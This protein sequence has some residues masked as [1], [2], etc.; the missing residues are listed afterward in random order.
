MVGCALEDNILLLSLLLLLL[1]NYAIFNDLHVSSFPFWTQ[2]PHAYHAI[3]MTTTIGAQHRAPTYKDAK[4]WPKVYKNT[5]GTLHGFE[6]AKV[7]SPLDGTHI[8]ALANGWSFI[9]SRA[10][11]CYSA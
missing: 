1:F 11:Y 10:L 3:T 9:G 5:S 6:I 4:A 8:H 2:T 7:I